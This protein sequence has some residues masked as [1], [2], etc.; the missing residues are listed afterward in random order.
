M[1]KEQSGESGMIPAGEYWVGDPCYCFTDH[2]R[3]MALL[4]SADYMGDHAILEAEAGGAIFVAS[5]TAHGDGRY[6]DQRGRSYPV[7]AGLLGVV[8]VGMEEEPES[9]ARSRDELLA[10]VTF[11]QP[12]RITY[13]WGTV[14][15]G[16]LVIE[17]DNEEDEEDEEECEECGWL[18]DDCNCEEVVPA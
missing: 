6:S 2:N 18:L 15:I 3:W 17:T 10:R 14:Q 16:H 1:A 5:R 8:P 12:F 4:E 7:D 9:W 11:E 13:D